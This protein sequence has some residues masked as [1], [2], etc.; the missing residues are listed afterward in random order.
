V[1]LNPDNEYFHTKLADQYA[2]MQ[3]ST[4]FETEIFKIRALR[5][6]RDGNAPQ[7]ATPAAR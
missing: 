6:A 7:P 5:R 2:T 1:N 4:D 3:R